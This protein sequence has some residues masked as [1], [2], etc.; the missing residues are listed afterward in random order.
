MTYSCE[1]LVLNNNKQN[2][3]KKKTLATLFVQHA[4][5]LHQPLDMYNNLFCKH[6][7]HFCASEIN[8]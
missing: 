7:K 4:N 6:V 8:L 1:L 2:M 5:T 3:K